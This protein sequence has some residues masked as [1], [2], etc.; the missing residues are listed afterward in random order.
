MAGAQFV[1][2]GCR[3]LVCRGQSSAAARSA[4]CTGSGRDQAHGT[5]RGAA[6]SLKRWRASDPGWVLM[7]NWISPWQYNSTALLRWR[8]RVRKAQSGEGAGQGLARGLVHA[9]LDEAEAAQGCAAGGVARSSRCSARVAAG[10]RAS[11]DAACVRA[12]RR[13]LH[14]LSKT[15]ASMASRAVRRL[16][17]FAEHVVEDFQRQ[18]AGVAR[19]AAPAQETPPQSQSPWPES[20]RW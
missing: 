18:V 1:R 9:K 6:A 12:A 13:F 11:P 3:G 8:P 4:A 7:T 10:A 2:P 20:L 19:A 16:R 5:H 17:R 14:S 15:A